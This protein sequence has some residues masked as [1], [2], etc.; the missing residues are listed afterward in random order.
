MQPIETTRNVFG[1]LHQ[2]LSIE[3]GLLA[4]LDFLHE[5][6]Q[7]A[8]RQILGDNAHSTYF[9]HSA[10]KLQVACTLIHDATN[11]NNSNN[12]EKWFVW[13]GREREN[14]SSN[15]PPQRLDDA[16][17]LWF[18]CVEKGKRDR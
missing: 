4:T 17:S 7:T 11:N 15:T 5:I 16:D 10:K 18:H 14:S 3:H 6:L 1:H 8:T 13:C 12:K 9:E 2:S